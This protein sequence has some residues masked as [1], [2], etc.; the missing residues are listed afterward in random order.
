M[1]VYGEWATSP[2]A[3]TR[4]DTLAFEAQVLKDAHAEWERQAAAGIPARSQFT[5]RLVKS[6]VGNLVIFERRPDGFFIR[7]MGSRISSIIGEMQG[8]MVADALP[9]EAAFNWLR[10]LDAILAM[11]KPRRVVKT[12]NFNNLN[13]LEAEIFIAPLCDD[14]GNANMVFTVTSF[15]AGVAPT[16]RLGDIIGSNS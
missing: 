9:P 1:A 8:R 2:S 11:G 10:E 12:V 15:R 3:L 4:D 5:P 6:F 16:R 13:Y 7:L 14:H